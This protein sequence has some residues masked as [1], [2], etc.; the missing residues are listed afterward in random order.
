LTLGGVY[1]LALIVNGLASSFDGT[2]N[3]VQA[4]KLVAY[5]STAS[6]LS[7]IFGLIPGLGFLG[8]LGLYSLYLFYLGLPVLMQSPPAKTLPYTALIVAAAIV[9]ALVI[10]PLSAILIGVS[11][12]SGAYSGAFTNVHGDIDGSVTLP[13]GGAVQL[14]KLQQAARAMETA[15]QRAANG[16]APARVSTDV[17]K[18]FLPGTLGSGLTRTS[19]SSAGGQVAGIGG[20]TVEGQYGG[21]GR[22]VT[23]DVIDMGSI[24]A[25]ASLGGAMGISG[26]Q[27]N[28]TSTSRMYQE[29]GHTVAEEYDS[30]SHHGSYTLIAASRFMVKAEGSGVTIAELRSIVKGVDLARLGRLAQ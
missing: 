11:M 9:V 16:Q 26:D 14:D 21:N 6:W 19:I 28:A 15:T 29:N 12:G 25:L 8:I 7:G 17:L 24:G 5:A 30:G 2:P 23:V 27:E 1:V 18:T 3:R 22:S 13:N 10:A 4:L 20:S